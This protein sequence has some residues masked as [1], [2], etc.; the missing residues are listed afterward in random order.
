MN[1]PC[2]RVWSVREVGQIQ[3]CRQRFCFCF[4]YLSDLLCTFC[5]ALCDIPVIPMNILVLLPSTSWSIDAVPQVV[6]RNIIS[7]KVYWLW[8]ESNLLLCLCLRIRL[9]T[10]IAALTAPCASANWFKH[11]GETWKLSCKCKP[12]RKRQ[13]RFYEHL[14]KLAENTSIIATQISTLIYCH[15]GG[16][17]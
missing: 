7:M 13:V 8:T 17:G 9:T 12:I 1:S 14:P 3:C 6:L 5:I 15:K 16:H 10:W 11:L 4:L 2:K